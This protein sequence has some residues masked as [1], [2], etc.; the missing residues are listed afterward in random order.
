MEFLY[1]EVTKKIIGCAYKVHNTL[2]SGFLEKVYENALKVELEKSGL[3]VEQQKAINVYYDNSVVG[4]Y[5]ADLVVND[6]IILEIKVAETINKV[7]EAQLLNYLRA[8]R[9]RVGLIINFGPKVAI[10]R[11]IL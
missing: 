4:Q 1:E 8:T 11:R 7:H 3:G 5:I 10:K 9:L 6:A 2:G